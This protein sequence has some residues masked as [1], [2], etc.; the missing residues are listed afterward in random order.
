VCSAIH[1]LALASPALRDLQL[2]RFGLEFAFPEFQFAHPL[3]DGSAAVLERSVEATA[4]RLGADGRSYLRLM[5]RPVAAADNLIEELLRP[6][7]FPHHPISLARFGLLSIRSASGLASS[8]F[9]GPR[10]QALLAGVAAHS[11]LKLNQSP[12]AGFALMLVLLAHAV[13]WPAVRG[14]SQRIA[15]ALASHL[16]SLGGEIEVG[17]WVTTMHDL[18]PS[19]AVLFDIT[20]RQLT[21]IAQDELPRRYT[22]ALNRFRYGPGVFKIDWALDGPVPW[23]AADC[24][25]AGTVHVG[26][27]LGEIAAS[28]DAVTNGHVTDKPY[29]LV[30]QQSIFDDTRAPRGQHTLWGYCHV[31]H[32]S[33]VD[34]TEAIENQ[35]ERFAP[36]FK[37]LILDRHVLDAPAMEKY[38]PNYVGGDINGGIQDLRGHLFRPLARLVP[39][40]TPNPRLYICSSS[41]PPGGGVHGLSGFFAAKAALARQLRS[42]ARRAPAPG[43]LPA[44]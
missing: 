17:R 40:T 28:E 22:R 3:D 42:A 39:Y 43:R 19:D 13:G 33:D 12:T 30:A 8:V 18:P 15:D 34:M 2:D 31:P 1:P 38:N 7:R 26:G 25:R 27:T 5:K 29:V 24:S 14:G 20:P 6:P 23:T 9:D 10:A 41:S 11:M 32:G 16:R 36:G 44:D 37:D 21:S 4:D 35:I